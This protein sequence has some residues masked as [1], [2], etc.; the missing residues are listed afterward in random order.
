MAEIGDVERFKDETAL[1]KY[2]GL[3]WTKHQS[4]KFEADNSRLIQGGNKYL[5]YYF[6]QAANKV[7]LHDPDYSSFYQSKLRETKKSPH[8]RALV[9]TA[10]KL[11]RLVYA[12]LRDQRLYKIQTK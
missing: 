1:A 5:R 3:T 2:A 10:R 12:L 4:G 11:V 8:K 9:L 6:C 7:R